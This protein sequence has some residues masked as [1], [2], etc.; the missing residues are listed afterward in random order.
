MYNS[1]LIAVDY[2][3]VGAYM[4]LLVAVAGGVA[5]RGRRGG[6]HKPPVSEAHSYFMAEQ[7]TPWYAAGAAFFASNIGSDAI[8]GL[9]SAGATGACDE[10]P[11]PG[12]A[13]GLAA[14]CLLVALM[15]PTATT[16]PALPVIR[17]LQWA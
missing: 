11:Q 3:V 6:P 7:S 5:W 17:H 8:I 2:V 9:S 13:G 14:S 4:A 16:T 1:S 10:G 12:A 15:L